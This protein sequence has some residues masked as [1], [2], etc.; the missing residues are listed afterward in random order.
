MDIV[1]EY[2]V[3]EVNK[4]K[5]IFYLLGGIFLFVII[6]LVVI[7]IVALTLEKEAKNNTH[8]VT[9]ID[10]NFTDTP[11]R[12]PSVSPTTT[13]FAELLSTIDLLYS[14]DDR[15]AGGSELFAAKFSN[16]ASPQYRAAVWVADTASIVGINVND[17]RMVSRYAL[18]TFYFATNGDEWSFCGRGSTYCDV[19]QEWLTA[20]NECD[21]Y[22]IEC[23]SIYGD[24]NVTTIFFRKSSIAELV[25][26]IRTTTNTLSVHAVAQLTPFTNALIQPPMVKSPTT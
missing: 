10:R 16:E 24:Y 6:V 1:P 23:D 12:A 13:T 22:A 3:I 17:P 21:W 26:V 5:K 14:P 8:I 18:A 15:A 7:A 20:A 25:V 9:K 11:S 19:S 4:K 2:Q